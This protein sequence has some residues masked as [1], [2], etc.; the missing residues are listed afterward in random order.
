MTA[1]LRLAALNPCALVF[2]LALALGLAGHAIGLVLLTFGEV[3]NLGHG[4]DGKR[5]RDRA[6]PLHE[7]ILFQ[8]LADLQ[9]LRRAETDLPRRAANLSA[10]SSS[11][12]VILV[13]FFGNDKATNGEREVWN[14]EVAAT[15]FSS[16]LRR[17][18]STSVS[19]A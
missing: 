3:S 13:F 19:L 1:A 16:R 14:G 2:R 6:A 5:L 8:L 17:M 4:G 7:D 12:Q 9:E 11:F 18:A 10:V 15:T